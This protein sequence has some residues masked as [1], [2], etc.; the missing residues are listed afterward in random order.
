M[1]HIPIRKVNVEKENKTDEGR[2][3]IT[4]RGGRG[5]GG[6]GYSKGEE[7]VRLAVEKSTNLK[8]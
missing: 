7:D 4:Y 5:V 1:V 6:D 8:E 2:L 3:M